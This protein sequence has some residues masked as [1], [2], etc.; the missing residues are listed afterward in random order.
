VTEL[1]EN[2]R[3][4]ASAVAQGAPPW[5]RFLL[6]EGA[7]IRYEASA[8]I[9]MARLNTPETYAPRFAEHL[10]RGFPWINLNA[11]GVLNG[12]LLVVV[13]LPEYTAGVPRSK[14]SVNLSGPTLVDGKPQW[15]VR[16]R[17]TVTE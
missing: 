10:G 17:Y 13:E 12:A 1:E 16:G 8:C 4:L 11:A 15:H 3:R 5:D 14:V 7:D 9:P 2:L 6:L